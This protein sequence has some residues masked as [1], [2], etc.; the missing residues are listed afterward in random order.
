MK[1]YEAFIKCP[2]CFKETSLTDK[3]ADINIDYGLRGISAIRNCTCGVQFSEN[4]HLH[5]KEKSM[6]T[7]EKII[8]KTE[9]VLDIKRLGEDLYSFIAE[10]ITG[11]P[12]GVGTTELRAK[13]NLL[14][15]ILGSTRTCQQVIN[16]LT[17]KPTTI[18]YAHWCKQEDLVIISKDCDDFCHCK[19]LRFL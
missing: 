10:G 8:E 14:L 11:S 4:E 1:E 5:F 16:L 15:R 18:Y 6:E 3:Q 19:S 7:I 12:I 13:Y 2:G 17:N 9:K